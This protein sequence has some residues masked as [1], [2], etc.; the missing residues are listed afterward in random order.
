M[1]YIVRGA[2]I[3]ALFSPAAALAGFAEGRAAFIKGDW[4]SVEVEMKPL[5]EK[6]DARAQL[7]L[8]LIY[9][10]GHGV[11]QNWGEA[12]FWFSEAAKHA[13]LLQDCSE[14]IIV[15]ILANENY[16]YSIEQAFGIAFSD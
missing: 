4:H 3:L 15:R 5:A 2:L 1:K 6:R 11:E 16:A 14:K 13:E 7:A 9:A 10:R 8:G 12:V